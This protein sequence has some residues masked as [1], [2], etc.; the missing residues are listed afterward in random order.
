MILIVLDTTVTVVYSAKTSLTYQC[1][2]VFGN[3]QQFVVH[4]LGTFFN[5]RCAPA[6]EL[7]DTF[8]KDLLSAVDS[9]Q[10]G[11]ASECVSRSDNIWSNVSLEYNKS[12]ILSRSRSSDQLVL[13]SKFRVL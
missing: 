2:V 3:D 12:A 10:T 11:G 4:F 8:E 9:P 13:R 7:R 5:A 1:E 6:L